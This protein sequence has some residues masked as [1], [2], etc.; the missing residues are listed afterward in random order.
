M[1]G[2]S[3]ELETMVTSVVDLRSMEHKIYQA[4][5]PHQQLEQENVPVYRQVGDHIDQVASVHNWTN[6]HGADADPEDIRKQLNAIQQ[7]ERKLRTHYVQA[8]RSRRRP[9]MG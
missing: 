5:V 9:S 6:V 1:D 2:D 3:P 4:K 8:K 7:T